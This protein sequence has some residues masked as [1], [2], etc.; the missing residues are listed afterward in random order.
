MTASAGYPSDDS[1]EKE[2]EPEKAEPTEEDKKKADDLKAAGNKELQGGNLKKAVILYGEAIEIN[3]RNAVFYANR[4]MA[5]IKLENY[6][7]ALLDGTEAVE[8][9]PNYIKGYY[10]KGTALLALGKLSEAKQEFLKAAKLEPRNPDCRSKL[11]EV[12]KA[13]RQQKFQ[14]AIGGNPNAVSL[15]NSVDPFENPALDP[16]NVTVEESYDGP[17]LEADGTLTVEF[18][19]ALLERFKDE[20][21]LHKRY[22][23]EILRQ[24][25]TILKAERTLVDV[26]IPEGSHFTVCGDV[27]G[28]FYDLCNIF[29]QNGK[30]S[31]ENPYLFNGD[32][33]DRGS[34]SVETILTLLGYKVLYPTGMHLN[35]GNHESTNM[36]K[37]YGFEGEVK[38]KCG[39]GVM[40]FF[41][42]LFQWLPLAHCL[43]SKVLVLHGGL[44]SK[45]DVTLD[46]IRKIERHCEPPDEGIMTEL[47]WSDPQPQPGRSP[48]KRGVGVGFG[49]DVAKRFLEKNGLE[50]LIRSHE[51][52]DNGYEIE[53]GGLTVTIFSAPNYCDQMGNKGAFIRMESDLK[54][55]YTTYSAV[56]HPAV[57]P[58][59]YASMGGFNFLNFLQ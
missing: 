20:K 15:T 3:P 18:M 13:I 51:C 7:S 34:F 19:D 43:A 26:D 24:A 40:S 6:G 56:P 9:D 57:R 4:A 27:H 54:P 8:V 37:M 46:D 36:N 45:D 5:H 41:T 35:R 33:V 1:P 53:H 25:H 52:K 2:P 39:D 22:V 44:F 17:H 23:L 30:P 12:E 29:A 11:Q 58:M 14:N 32:F 50:R 59:Q 47:L 55:H 38:H 49:P 48:S 21:R 10:R 31:D 16:A 42:D 28:Q